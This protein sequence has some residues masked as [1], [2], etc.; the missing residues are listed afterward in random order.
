[1]LIFKPEPAETCRP[2]NT[3]FGNHFP[4][5]FSQSLLEMFAPKAGLTVN[6]INVYNT[7]PPNKF[8]VKRGNLTFATEISKSA[9]A[10][11]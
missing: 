7:T 3:P 8:D 6:V 9:F 1:M 10:T 11:A 4:K 5:N 2:S